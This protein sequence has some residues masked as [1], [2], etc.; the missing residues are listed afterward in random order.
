MNTT[1]LIAGIMYKCAEYG[2]T[3][4]DDI[5]NIIKI[6]LNMPGQIPQ[7][8][9][10][11]VDWSKVKSPAAQSFTSPGKKVP[12][13]MEGARNMGAKNMGMGQARGK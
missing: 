13:M 9:Q 10:G 1:A 5:H 11:P 3:D 8:M 6:A 2:I 7:Q 4:A 12:Q